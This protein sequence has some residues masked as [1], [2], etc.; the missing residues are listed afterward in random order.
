M[1]HARTVQ[2]TPP[3]S[4]Q[5]PTVLFI[6]DVRLYREALVVGLTEAKGVAV[7]GHCSG[8]EALAWL[9][10]VQVDVAL[11]DAS[12]SIGLSLAR[13]IRACAPTVRVL[14]VAIG[15]ESRR[16]LECA[17]AGFSGYLSSDV[18]IDGLVTEVRR[19]MRGELS[20]SPRVAALLF[21]R[22]A[23]LGDR[24]RGKTLAASPAGPDAE[25]KLLTVRETE[26][27]QL[28][29]AGLTNKEI[30]LE[31]RI[32]AATVKNHVHNILEKLE[33]PRR[34]AIRGRLA[35]SCDSGVGLPTAAARANSSTSSPPQGVPRTS[36]SISHRTPTIKLGD[37]RSLTFADK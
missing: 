33:A 7:A 15:N 27:A 16:V 1:E 35:S 28:I 19:V 17:E 3:A 23:T 5:I 14:G 4:A 6:S 31:L 32:S 25:G 18:G 13:Q 10:R 37:S 21:E 30:A 8:A 9:G 29:N 22:L 26:V 20:C 11:V 36:S 2:C 24:R 12:L 34:A